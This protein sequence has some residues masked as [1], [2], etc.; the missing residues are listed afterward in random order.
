M[1]FFSEGYVSELL[2]MNVV[3]RDGRLVGRVGDIGV[4]LGESFPLVTKLLLRPRGRREPLILPWSVIRSV[5]TEAIA[6]T[7]PH[8]ELQ[9]TQLEEGEVLLVESVLDNQI[10]DVEG[11]RVV[12]V[13]DLKLGAVQGQ[14]RLVAVGVGTRSLLRRLNIEGIALRLW[15]WF[16]RRP[17]ERL[18][19]WEHVHSL[20][21]TSQQLRLDLE[22]EKL[23]RLNPAD[24]ADI[25]GELSALDRATVVSG[26][27]EETAAA[28]MEEMEF[29]LQQAVLDSL[30]DE[31]AADIL[32]EI[33]PDDAADLVGDLP[34]ERA[35]QLL[36]LMEPEEASDVKELLKYPDDTAGG[37]MT[38]E[39]VA[40]PAGMTAQEAIG[41]LRK[42]GEE[43][44][45]IY[46]CYV[47]D[48]EKR[49]IGV[50]SLRDLIVAPPTRVID[51]IMVRGLISVTAETS[52]EETAGL[53]A[54]YNLLAIPVVDEGK[55]LVGIVTVDDAIA[56]VLPGRLK[57]QL[58]KVFAR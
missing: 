13:N 29:E 7:H 43:A 58:P 30:E 39:Y 27:D 14:V 32:E 15:S 11:H 53:I 55:R 49:L 35:D 18:I 56:A 41:Y 26:L 10:V 38:P 40:V 54:R 31:K 46:Y 52:H 47:L 28:A 34:K 44:E 36:G 17:H 37:L 21:P 24:L 20:D 45:T 19:S 6:L 48:D 4:E 1:I 42:A 12:R 25:L 57:K 3:D 22:R 23:R 51:D 9:S 5:S 33:D 8:G 2:R 50:F 16:G